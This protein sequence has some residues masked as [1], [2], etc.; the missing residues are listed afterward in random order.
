MAVST[1][2]PALDLDWVRARFP[3]RDPQWTLLDNAGGSFPLRAVV[4]RTAEHMLEYA[5]QSGGGYPRSLEAVRRMDAGRA[6]GALVFGCEPEELAFGA[7]A[8]QLAHF[9]ARSLAPGF[10]PGDEVIV[11]NLDHETNIAPWRSLEREGLVVREWACEPDTLDLAAERL[12]EL[13]SERTRLV[14]FTHCSNITGA[15]Q[16]AAAL[17]A[18]V[19]AAGA[20]SVVDGVA[21]APHRRVDVRALGAD[22]YLASA[23]KFYGPHMGLLYGRRASWS[24]LTSLNHRF[25]EPT[26]M[27]N[28]L[29]LG[30]TSYELVAGLSAVGAYFCELARHHGAPQDEAPER[31]LER[32]FEAIAAHEQTLA[33]PLVDFVESHPRTRMVG[34]AT[35][36]SA[37]RA[38]T[39]SFQVD[40]ML[41]SELATRLEEKR[42]AVRW[43]HFYAERLIQALGLEDS[44]GVVR[45][46]LVHYD[47]PE[48]VE[49]L[50][51]A[52]DE[53]L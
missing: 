38:P 45:A 42:V 36:A 10:A 43:G 28:M 46:S 31:L 40:G 5:V 48:D 22:F 25:V 53:L 14:C 32:A 12:D 19:R 41:S 50:L 20:L 17:C 27:K 18:R 15:L 34:P 2:T 21:Y 7:S 44:D 3:E 51:S 6:A 4:E 16:D 9:L 24:S 35:G 39:L 37:R 11:T 23:Y 30:S 8:T 29:E 33:A 49:R 47:A 26:S 52:L 1:S 13:L